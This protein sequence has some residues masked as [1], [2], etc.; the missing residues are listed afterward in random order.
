MQEK[1]QLENNINKTKSNLRTKIALV[2]SCVSSMKA[3]SYC[4]ALVNS[5]FY[6]L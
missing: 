2:S 3:Y 4:S 6:C 1:L 5:A